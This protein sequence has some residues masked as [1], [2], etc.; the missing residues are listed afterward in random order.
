M[1]ANKLQVI[2][3]IP[4]PKNFK[5]GNYHCHLLFFRMILFRF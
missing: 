3:T 2:D 1:I 4:S 5:Q